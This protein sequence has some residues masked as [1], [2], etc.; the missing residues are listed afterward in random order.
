MKIA[1]EWQIDHAAS[2]RVHV[3]ELTHLLDVQESIIRAEIANSA[4][5]RANA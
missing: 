2:S 5:R 4:R 1:I 3:D